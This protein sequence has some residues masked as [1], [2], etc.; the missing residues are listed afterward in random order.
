MAAILSTYSW[1][2]IERYHGLVERRI[3]EIRGMEYW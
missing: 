3:E 2:E 1:P